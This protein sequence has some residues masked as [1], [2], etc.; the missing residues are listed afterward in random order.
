MT[1]IPTSEMVRMLEELT[2]VEGTVSEDYEC[3]G[4]W[5][6]V[7][8]PDGR[9]LECEDLLQNYMGTPWYPGKPSYKFP[10]HRGGSNSYYA[11]LGR[12]NA[13]ASR[14]FLA[15]YDPTR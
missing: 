5:N 1:N 2:A 13:K 6:K 3:I 10:K 14:A 8:Y 9:C 4:C 12:K 15:Q 7:P 11:K